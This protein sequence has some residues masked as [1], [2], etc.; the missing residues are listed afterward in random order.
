[1]EGTLKKSEECFFIHNKRI[2]RHDADIYEI[3]WN[4]NKAYLSVVRVII[5]IF[6]TIMQ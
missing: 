4:T 5:L 3:V 1:M 6:I 2:Y